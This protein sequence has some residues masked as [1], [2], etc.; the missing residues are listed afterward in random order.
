MSKQSFICHF[1]TFIQDVLEKE[2]PDTSD[3]VLLLEKASQISSA[4]IKHIYAGKR[5]SQLIE[6]SIE[7]LEKGVPLCGQE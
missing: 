2:L 6:N 7:Q 4:T 1:A 3:E 5:Q